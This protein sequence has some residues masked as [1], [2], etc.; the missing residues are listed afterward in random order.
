MIAWP[1]SRWQV[2]FFKEHPEP[3]AI[4][5]VVRLHRLRTVG[6]FEGC[7]QAEA[8]TT[9]GRSLTSWVFGDAKPA[10]V[11]GGVNAASATASTTDY[12]WTPSDSA[13][14]ATLQQWA[15]TA[16]G[17]SAPLSMPLIRPLSVE[18]VA[19]GTA[20]SASAIVDLLVQLHSLAPEQRVVAQPAAAAAYAAEAAR[21]GVPVPTPTCGVAGWGGSQ[22]CPLLKVKDPGA[23]SATADVYVEAE[24]AVAVVRLL[25]RHLAI[26][27]NENG[28]AE[29]WLRLR[30]VRLVHASMKTSPA[31]H[32]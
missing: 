28:G 4:G 10:A 24:A 15:R 25:H 11:D 20:A 32:I 29:Q 26:A 21:R 8:T 17:L 30:A 22:P 12:T 3:P 18:D 9:R 1:L 2:C 13:R 31:D 19:T 27:A 23:S 7:R 14:V 6:E 16:L 5:S